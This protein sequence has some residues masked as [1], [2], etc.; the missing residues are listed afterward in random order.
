LIEGNEQNFSEENLSLINAL[1]L[2]EKPFHFMEMDI[3]PFSSFDILVEQ[4]D[5]Y[6]TASYTI[7]YLYMVEERIFQIQ[8]RN[9]CFGKFNFIHKQ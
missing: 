1:L 3:L 6:R 8:I 7:P 4:A 5:K 9:F 2:D